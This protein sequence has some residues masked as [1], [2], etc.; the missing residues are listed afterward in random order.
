MTTPTILDIQK[1]QTYFRTGAGV[2]KAVDGV[3]FSIRAGETYALVG[4]SGCGKT[5]TALSIL[6]LI[7]KPAGYIAG[8]VI[9]LGDEPISSLPPREMRRIRGNRI[10]MIFQEPMTALNPVFTIGNQISEAIAL[11]QPVNRSEA[12]QQT[13]DMLRKVGIP[14]P[15][16]RYGEYPH[17]MSGGM[18]QRVMIAM[19]LACKPEVLIADEPT[20]A[21]DVT[22]QSQI[23][24]LIQQLKQELNTAVLLITHDMGV[25]RENADR[26]GV[27]YAGR[28]VEEADRERLF[29]EPTHPYTRLL[30]RSLPSRAMRHEPLATISGMVPKATEFPSGCRFSNR[31]PFV[32]ERCRTE[33]V[34]D[35]TPTEGHRAACFLL[36]PADPSPTTPALKTVAAAP[37]VDIDR[38]IC[39]LELNRMHM[40]F[41]IRKGLFRRTVGR[42]RAVDGVDL[43]IHKGETLALVGESGCGKTTVGKC[44]IRLYNPTGGRMTFDT[45]D[46]TRL[47]GS[48][49]KPFRR[50]IQMIFQDP[51]SSLNPRMLI[52]NTLMQGM[53]THGIGS[54]PRERRERAQA[55]LARVGLD[56]IV[57]D[58]YPHEFS[59]GQRQRIGIARALAV[60][61]ELIIC[62]EATSSLDVSVQAQIIN[63]LKELQAEL[64]LSYLFIT[65]DLSVVKYLADRVAVMYLGRIVEEGTNGDIFTTPKHPYTQALLSA[66]PEV[67]AETGHKKIVV[68][69]D[70]PSNI[71]PPRGCH[72]HPRCPDA[73]PACAEAYPPPV[74]FGDTHRCRCILYDHS[75]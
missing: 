10:S 3:S 74:H 57:I 44:A 67:D 29:S 18:R 23:L 33:S 55:L 41:P 16:Q 15:A 32:M 64:G 56:P 38:S 6:Q 43:T 31:C 48:R 5:V 25:V 53:T 54:S 40:H 72:F 13:V 45:E 61:P 62:D 26:V 59:G 34:P 68:R 70:V 11:H 65:H 60:E 58:R 50:K 2:A 51:F 46:I 4:E 14:D 12:R 28:I 8:G 7:P 37:D 21:L 49:I 35:Y 22:I 17:Q 42:V 9:R 24:D 20:T 30:L 75:D 1:L 52:G 63:L 47:S 27:M 36:D 73:M 69:G 66:I 71:K 39:R 19:A